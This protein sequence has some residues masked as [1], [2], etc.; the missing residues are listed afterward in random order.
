VR[1]TFAQ[2]HDWQ[3]TA[4]KAL[5]EMDIQAHARLPA[6]SWSQ[7]AA[8]RILRPGTPAEVAPPQFLRTR[9]ASTTRGQ[10]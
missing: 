7:P 8:S 1:V 2:P 9:T 3:I 10:P 6:A 4:P 5:M